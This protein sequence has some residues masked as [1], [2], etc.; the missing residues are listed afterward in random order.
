MHARMHESAHKHAPP[1]EGALEPKAEGAAEAPNREVPVEAPK[2]ADVPPGF[3]KAL[4]KPP[5]AE[6]DAPKAGAGEDVAPK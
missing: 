1:K 2:G 5:N 4:P 3:A 6:L